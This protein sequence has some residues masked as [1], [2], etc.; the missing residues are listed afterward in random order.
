MQVLAINSGGIVTDPSNDLAGQITRCVDDANSYY[1]LRY[2]PT[3]TGKPFTYHS[4]DVK[5]N[6]PGLVARA[7]AGYYEGP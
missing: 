3:E 2:T 4:I 6:R 7:I 1:T 5:V